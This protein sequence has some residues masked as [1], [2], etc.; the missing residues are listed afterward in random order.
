METGPWPFGSRA[1]ALHRAMQA[2]STGH[3]RR[4]A[5]RSVPRDSGTISAPPR[6][7]THGQCP[8]A[9]TQPTPSGRA[10]APAP[11]TAQGCPGAGCPRWGC[12]VLGW[13]CS[14]HRVMRYGCGVP[15]CA[16]TRNRVPWVRAE[17]PGSAWAEHRVPCIGVGDTRLCPSWVQG[18]LCL[19]VGCQAVPGTSTEYPGLEQGS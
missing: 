7:D 17:E 9:G 8:G 4:P 12:R 19:A 15:C 16:R 1:Q 10:A 5:A 18:S 6:W 3:R 13:P 2:W 11:K 14:K